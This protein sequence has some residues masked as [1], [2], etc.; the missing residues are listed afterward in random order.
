MKQEGIKTHLVK[1]IW[2]AY[3]AKILADNPEYWGKYHNKIHNF[4]IYHKLNYIDTVYG[5]EIV[6]GKRVQVPRPIQTS[7]IV[8]IYSYT[9]FRKIVEC[10]FDKAKT[11][12]VNGEAVSINRCG[13]IC[14]KRVE[15]DFRSSSQR[16]VNWS[17]TRLQPKIFDPVAG[18]NKYAKLIYFTGDDWCRIG[19]YKPGMRN[20]TVYEFE[21]SNRNSGATTGFK[22]EFSEALTSNPLLKYRYLYCPIKDYSK[23]NEKNVS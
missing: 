16:L 9:K 1:H 3:A 4:Y 7:K 13:K 18:K 17:K 20:E 11:A 22:H 8:E 19:W 6:D 14:A 23:D 5:H 15:R 12:I 10:F 21:P 2:E